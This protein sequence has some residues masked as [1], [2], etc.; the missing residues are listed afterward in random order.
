MSYA[1]QYF[2][3]TI[4]ALDT[5]NMQRGHWP[6][7]VLFS[8]EIPYFCN[9]WSVNILPPPLWW[10]SCLMWSSSHILTS[11]HCP[12]RVQPVPKIKHI[13]PLTIFSI[14]DIHC[15][16]NFQRYLLEATWNYMQKT[17]SRR[18]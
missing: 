3:T 4:S 16:T 11:H 14:G 6:S 17:V 15:S 9:C 5:E 7:P 1:L 10:H 2:E 8:S 12:L 13:Y 18:T